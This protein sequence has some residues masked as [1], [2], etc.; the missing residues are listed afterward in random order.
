MANYVV[1]S[2]DDADATDVFDDF[3]AAY[4]AAA[5]LVGKVDLGGISRHDKLASHPIRVRTS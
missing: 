2:P 4:K 3:D 1:R 5:T